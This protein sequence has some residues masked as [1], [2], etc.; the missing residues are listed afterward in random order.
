MK[1]TLWCQQWSDYLCKLP[2]ELNLHEAASQDEMLLHVP[3]G[4]TAQQLDSKLLVAYWEHPGGDDEWNILLP[5]HRDG[6]TGV[7]TVVFDRRPGQVPWLRS[8]HVP[9]EHFY[10]D[11][12]SVFFIRQSFVSKF[13]VE[14]VRR[15]RR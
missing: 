12:A 13:K 10:G 9:F 5:I 3:V 8:C 14:L 1:Q 6:N 11:D 15:K 4:V 2:R 7:A